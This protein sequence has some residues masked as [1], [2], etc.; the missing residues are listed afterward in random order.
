MVVEAKYGIATHEGVES[1]VYMSLH[2]MD[3]IKSAEPYQGK[4]ENKKYTILVNASAP[5]EQGL[6]NLEEKLKEDEHITDVK[7]FE[8]PAPKAKGKRK[9]K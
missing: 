3:E 6:L 8:A 7:R 2:H 5:D 9:G 4:A 1:R